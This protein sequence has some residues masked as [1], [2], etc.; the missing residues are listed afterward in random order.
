MFGKFNQNYEICIKSA[1]RTNHLLT[2]LLSMLL[3]LAGAA[4]MQAQ[5]YSSVRLEA[6]GSEIPE[7]CLPKSDSI[8]SCPQLVRNKS[9]IVTYNDAREIS[10]LGISLF[11]SETKML[12]N[13]PV[14]DFIER[15]ML[16][17]VLE[18]SNDNILHKLDRLKMTL[19]KN[20][21]TFGKST[22]TS[23]SQVLDELQLPAKF[24]LMKEDEK[25]AAV[26]EYNQQDQFIFAF[27]AS[28]E[29]IFGTDKKE[30]DELLNKSLFGSGMLCNDSNAPGIGVTVTE[31]S[32]AYNRD[33]DFY[34]QKGAEFIL[35]SVNSNMYYQ[36]KGNKFEL[37][38]TK[39]LPMESFTNLV[40]RNMGEMNHKLH[41]THR[42]YGNFS[43]DFNISLQEFLCYFKEEYNFFAGATFP[44]AKDPSK[45][46]L[47]AI[48]RNKEYSYLHL[49]I[50]SAPVDNLFSQGGLL[51][52][53]FYSNI[54]Q[55]NI[56]NLLGNTTN[57]R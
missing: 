48:L 33:K 24:S 40:M 52:A 3:M 28:H 27:P 2:G 51:T 34:T 44:D 7:A 16:E 49:L 45:I 32:L 11:S 4:A 46:K 50:I 47:T 23:I 38:F 31:A 41:V 25:F 30:S 14:C 29:L 43:P 20:G 36:K 9:L 54:P 13:L 35:P 1:M 55:N 19:S 18:P 10:H 26:W 39:D 17:L 6:L 21:L 22:F 5:T 12:L 42:M 53:E 37:L 57:N 56:R 15:M 8:F